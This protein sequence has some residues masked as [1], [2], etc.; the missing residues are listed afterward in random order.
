MLDVYDKRFPG[1]QSLSVGLRRGRK[2][3]LLPCNLPRT[4]GEWGGLEFC[5]CSPW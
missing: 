5:Y 2:E 1:T 4:W 3:T